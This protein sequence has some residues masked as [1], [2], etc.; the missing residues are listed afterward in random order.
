MEQRYEVGRKERMKRIE[1]SYMKW[2]LEMDAKT[3]GYLVREELQRGK[4]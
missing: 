2:M 1:Q 3:P 4:A